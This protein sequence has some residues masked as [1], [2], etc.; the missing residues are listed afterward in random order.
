MLRYFFCL[1]FVVALLLHLVISV[2][3]S[4]M[5]KRRCLRR[6]FGLLLILIFLSVGAVLY[7]NQIGLPGFAKR[8]VQ[9]HL[10]ELGIE[11]DFDWLRMDFD[12]SWKA[13]QLTFGQT[14]SEG[15]L[16]LSL[17]DATVLPDYLSLFSDQPSVKEFGISGLGLRAEVVAG[18]TNLPPVSLVWP[19]AG[20]YWS[21]DEVL[22][23]TN[24]QGAAFGFKLDISL[25]ITNAL[26]LRDILQNITGKSDR[27]RPSSSQDSNLLTSEMV[28]RKLKPIKS[29]LASLL[30]SRRQ[31]HFQKEPI[32]KFSFKGDAA[33]PESLSGDVA[34]EAEE[35]SFPMGGFDRFKLE[36]NLFNKERIVGGQERFK[37]EFNLV[38]LNAG[39]AKSE[40]LVGRASST[41]LATN[42]LPEAI[43][44]Q[45]ESTGI[46]FSEVAME[47]GSV[48]G[49]ATQLQS[50]SGYFKHQLYGLFR[51]CNFGQERLKSI[52]WSAALTNS[53]TSPLP[54]RSVVNLSLTSLTSS[55]GGFDSAD[56][57]ANVD[58]VDSS[59]DKDESWDYWAKLAPYKIHFNSSAKNITEGENLIIDD[60]LLEGKWD[61]PNLI[62]NQFDAKFEQGGIRASAELDVETRL[63]KATSSIDFDLYKII[64]HLSP[65]A[66]RWIQQFKWVKAPVVSSTIQATLPKW[67]DKNPDW[68]AQV[69]PSLVINGKVDSGPLSFRGIEL[70]GAQTDLQYT[71]QVWLLPNL[72]ARRA[73]GDLKFAL[74]SQTDSRDFHF[75]F[76]ST[77][78]P[79]AVIPALKGEKQKRGVDFFVFENPPVIEGQIWGRWR[80]P[81]QTGFDAKFGATNFTFRAQ[82][83][84][85]MTAGM[86][87]TNGV[88][89]AVNVVV[90]RHEGVVTLDALSLDLGEKRL[91]L[92]NGVGRVDPAAVSKAIGPKTA[93]ALEPYQFI[94]PPK[95]KVNGWIQT[96]PGRNP[97]SLHVEVDGGAFKFNRFNSRDMNGEIF[98]TGNTITLTNVVSEF[99]GGDLNGDLFAKFNDKQSSEIDFHLQV[100]QMGLT[101]FMSDILGR[102]SG[103]SG[104]MDGVLD[105][106]AIS[107]DW[108]SWN[109]SASVTLKDGYLW[110]LPLLGIFSQVLDQM[111]P[112]LVAGKFSKGTGDFKVVNSIVKTRNLELKSPLVRLQY[113]GHVDFKGRISNAGVVAEPLRDAWVIGPVIGP[114]LNLALKP[115]ERMLKFKVDGTLNKPQMELKHIPKLLLVPVQIPLKLFDDIVP[116]DVLTPKTKE[117]LEQK[118]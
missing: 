102:D 73:E 17:D 21:G 26:V 12:G 80:E 56:I 18:E 94:D 106:K 110:E 45:I 4:Y 40:S 8:G 88:F 34:V 48:K 103:L 100:K 47:A 93:R 116:D 58:R 10:A 14:D 2:L 114:V 25:S 54:N 107:K 15:E 66:Q 7:L 3:K 5:S 6:L 16:G 53:L 99:Y 49:S 46:D 68:G 78:N 29:Q 60:L 109:G 32:I 112:G 38:G 90:A 19:K 113:T 71:N 67:A 20:L 83:V 104:Q 51:E 105:I 70:D 50:K 11:L 101:G 63:V 108:S 62:M 36:L 77:I 24:L 91:Y 9:Q 41:S 35:F 61:A 1:S 13:K 52:D 28:A 42:L 27:T 95:V 72:V 86:A 74:R 118:D 39:W 87:L 31:I 43:E 69:G 115:I 75:D 79:R 59:I 64:D 92:T 44:Y 89:S 57:T 76:R 37:G 82:Q 111:A 117:K 81:D 22:S 84:D 97:A 33:A 55:K 85:S 30:E 98:W 65:K 96:G 23:S